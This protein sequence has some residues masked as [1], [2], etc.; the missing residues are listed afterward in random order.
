MGLDAHQVAF[1]VKKY[2]SHRRVAGTAEI[3]EAI[4]LQ[5]QRDKACMVF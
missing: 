3:L 1:A 5:E 2:K 4:K